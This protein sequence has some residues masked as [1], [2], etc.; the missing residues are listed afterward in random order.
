MMTNPQLKIFDSH[1]HLADEA[2]EG[3]FDGV[4]ERARSSGIAGVICPGDS[5]ETSR[6][7]ILLAA[8]YPGFIYAAVGLH[9]YEAINYNDDIERELIFLSRETGCVAIGEIGLDFRKDGTDPSPRDVQ[10]SAFSLQLK[11]SGSLD[12]PAIVH[13]RNA[14][15]ELIGILSQNEYK[16]IRGVVHCFSGTNE[17]AHALIELG[18]H[19]GF[20]G[21]LT[22][23][24]A[25]GLREAAASIPLEKILIE[26]DAPYLTPHPYRGKFPNEPH[27]VRLVAETLSSCK[28]IPLEE[29]CRTT[30]NN[31]I[32]LFG[33]KSAV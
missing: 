14:Y 28:G 8:E 32:G 29:V 18:W 17:E 31:T 6:K 4:L 9:P 12:L 1:A 16:G 5:I 20:T 11:L 15:P 21:T 24:N 3:I 30:F 25:A 7:T 13:C 33:I 2:F 23:K 10:R 22:F 19:I 27:Y 26:T